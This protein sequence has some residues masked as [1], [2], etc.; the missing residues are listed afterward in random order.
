MKED[1]KENFYQT[2]RCIFCPLFEEYK[3]AGKRVIICPITK[4]EKDRQYD[5]C[6]VICPL[7][8]R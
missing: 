8:E 5:K 3:V 1:N 2:K 7:F 4:E 6:N